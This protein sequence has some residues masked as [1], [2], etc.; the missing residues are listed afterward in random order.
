MKYRILLFIVFAFCVG[1][2]I[3]DNK[4]WTITKEVSQSEIDDTVT[5]TVTAS[6]I[7]KTKF[8]AMLDNETCTSDRIENNEKAVFTIID[9]GFN[10][11]IH[12]YESVN[13]LNKPKPDGGYYKKQGNL[14]LT[15]F[16]K[17][18]INNGFDSSEKSSPEDAT[19]FIDV[20]EEG[21]EETD[22]DSVA[23]LGKELQNYVLCGIIVVVVLLLLLILLIS[24][25]LILKRLLIEQKEIVELI[26]KNLEKNSANNQERSNVNLVKQSGID[27]KIDSLLEQFA[28]L[29]GTIENLQ[30]SVTRVSATATINRPIQGKNDI[31]TV[32]A[33]SDNTF[34]ES[35]KYC[36]YN[37]G[38]HGFKSKDFSDD[39][40]R[41][42]FIIYLGNGK[43]EYGI[44]SILADQ[45]WPVL[46]L[47]E[48]AVELSGDKYNVNG[49]TVRTVQRGVLVK[50]SN[51]DF[52]IREK[53]KVEIV[54]K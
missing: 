47:V 41:G 3:A 43:Y 19:A 35:I 11:S 34:I 29:S 17:E 49:K 33:T 8:P 24:L 36:G 12:V 14:V 40:N 45:L 9:Y 16:L 50:D 13:D 25:S 46:A 27:G 18:K 15:I 54:T 22:Y 7:G 5:V 23:E 42:Q 30:Q 2:I 51:G 53:A 26:S 52:T 10:D 37:A 38:I 32:P 48:N 44:N 4:V 21:T 31:Q 1:N 6:E 20:E 39:S 28:L